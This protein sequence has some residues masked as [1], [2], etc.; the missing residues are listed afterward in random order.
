M[1]GKLMSI[2]DDLVPQ[3][4]ALATTLSADEIAEVQGFLATGGPQAGKAKRR[5]A[6]AVVELYH[7]SDAATEAE[8]A[9]DRQFKDRR[10]PEEVEEA[11][12]PVDAVEGDNV[13]LPRVLAELGLASSRSEARRLIK[14]G[15]VKVNGEPVAREEVGL[16]ELEGALVQVGKRRFVRL[17]HGDS[18][19]PG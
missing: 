7:G 18:E 15:G 19:G 4:A 16:S 3:Y 8:E 17:L 9:F 10:A 1:F 6:G 13:Y 14:Q 12:I 5:V 11:A 2:P